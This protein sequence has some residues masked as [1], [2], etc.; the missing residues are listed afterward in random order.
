MKT[1][2]IPITNGKP[3]KTAKQLPSPHREASGG[4]VPAECSEEQVLRI[5]RGIDD[6]VLIHGAGSSHQ[7]TLTELFGGKEKWQKL[8]TR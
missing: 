6:S 7:V 4:R 2:H 8:Q 3:F 1:R 5:H